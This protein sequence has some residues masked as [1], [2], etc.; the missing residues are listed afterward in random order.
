MFNY[1]F[2]I[3]WF[4]QIKQCI[5]RILYIKMTSLKHSTLYKLVFAL[6][7]LI[8]AHLQL[9]DNLKFRDQLKN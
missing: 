2:E 9:K 5:E 8:T 7:L 4:E 6:W 1:S 3:L